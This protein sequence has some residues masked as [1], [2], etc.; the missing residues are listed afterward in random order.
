MK[1]LLLIAGLLVLALAMF[2]GCGGGGA[3]A[4][5]EITGRADWSPND[6]GD[7]EISIRWWGGDARHTAIIEALNIFMARYENIS[8]DYQY[9][10][11][12]GYLDQLTMDLGAG[13]TPDIV[14]SNFAWIHAFGLGTNVFLNHRDVD[15]LLD[16]SEWTPS[17]L[18]YTTTADGQLAGVPHGIT[19]RV[20]VYSTEMM[21]AH[22]LS[23]FPATFEELI[24]LGESVAANNATLDAGA[25]MYPFFPVGN[26]SWD[27]ILFTMLYN[28]TGRGLQL[29]GEIQ[30]TVD[31]VEAMFELMGRV[32]ASGALPTFEQQEAPHDTSN[33]VWMSGRGGGVFEWVGNIFLAG[34]NFL[35]NDP[36]IRQVE[37]LGIALLPAVTPGGRQNVMQRP[38][39]VHSISGTTDYPELAAYLLNFLY[40]DEDAL[41]AIAHQFGVPLSR[42]AARVATQDDLIWGL[43][44]EG[45]D[46]IGRNVGLMCS[47]FEDPLLRP[48][49]FAAIEAFRTGASTAREAAERWVNGQQ[50]QLELIA[51]LVDLVD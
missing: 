4:P 27:I 8:I 16:L 38:S 33:P 13:T 41:R 10:A 2:T 50:S 9:G 51:A 29:D 34:G 18:A 21:A 46:L 23:T 48:E 42:T 25:N 49:R 15:H 12:G 32:I 28:E 20:V 17:L 7:T 1:K 36:G 37:G 39:L 22:G 43:Q 31:E 35:D 44:A 40:T 5:S 14:Q 3:G 11:F 30:Y 24:A 26:E 45:Q 19:G 47:F 6:I